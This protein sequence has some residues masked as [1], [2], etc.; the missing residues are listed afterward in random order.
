[1]LP[2]NNDNTMELIDNMDLYN[3]DNAIP[4][5]VSIVLFTL[6][7]VIALIDTN[8]YIKDIGIGDTVISKGKFY[9]SYISGY[10]TYFL[11]LTMSMLSL[12]ILLSLIRIAIVT[13]L[14]ILRPFGANFKATEEFKQTIFFKLKVALKN[15]ALWILGMYFIEKFFMMFLLWIPLLIALITL[16]YA[17]F[18]YPQEPMKAYEDNGDNE[19]ALQNG[20]T[21]HSHMMFNV[22][23]FVAITVAYM[24]GMFAKKFAEQNPV[25]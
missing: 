9:Y 21:I 24:L 22:S 15:N 10:M 2:I 23:V 20:N 25:P 4:V 7:T 16:G 8:T 12:Y 11:K 5:L 18:V 1:M 17:F 6:Q 3:P 14:N 19:I 13:I